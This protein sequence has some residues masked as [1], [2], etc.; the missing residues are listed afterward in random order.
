[1][2]PTV[3]KATPQIRYKTV[4]AQPIFD[5]IEKSAVIYETRAH[6]NVTA[7]IKIIFLNEKYCSITSNLTSTY[8][9]NQEIKSFSE[10]DRKLFKFNIKRSY[11]ISSN[12]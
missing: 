7:Q 2:F 1:M 11:I 3:E 9:V 12:E 10:S 8:I 4:M 6:Q 5:D